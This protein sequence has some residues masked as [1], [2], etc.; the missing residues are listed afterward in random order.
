[1]IE[2]LEQSITLVS[3]AKLN[4]L[5]YQDDYPNDNQDDLNTDKKRTIKP[6]QTSQSHSNPSSSQSLQQLSSLFMKD[7]HTSTV[8][9]NDPATYFLH[10]EST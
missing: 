7:P 6:S 1:M 9:N 8:T 4:S 5:P 3:Y 2:S 10:M